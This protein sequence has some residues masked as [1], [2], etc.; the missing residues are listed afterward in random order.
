MTTD[1]PYGWQKTGETYTCERCG[2]PTN[3][4]TPFPISQLDGLS[5][6]SICDKCREAEAMKRPV[7]ARAAGR[8]SWNDAVTY[9]R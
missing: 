4:R 6:Y 1:V 5:G 8:R 7:T 3:N 2:K 9:P